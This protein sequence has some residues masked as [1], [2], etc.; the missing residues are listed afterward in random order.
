MTTMY[1][2]PYW[3]SWATFRIQSAD[4]HWTGR[5]T[6]DDPWIIEPQ[7]DF[8]NW[9]EGEALRPLQPQSVA[10]GFEYRQQEGRLLTTMTVTVEPIASPL[11]NPS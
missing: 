4:T 6:I 8:W 5:G 3:A 2:M 1:M 9:F 7:D 10:L 11:S